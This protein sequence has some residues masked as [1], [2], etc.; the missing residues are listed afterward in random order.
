MVEFEYREEESGIFGRVF[1]PVITAEVKGKDE[2]KTFIGYVDSGADISIAP[3]SFGKAL[4]LPLSKNLKEVKGI[5]DARVPIS[6]HKVD[7]KIGNVVLKV[8]FAIA[9]IE[10]IPYVLGRADVFKFFSINF[11]EKLKKVVFEKEV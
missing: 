2:W 10:K 4:G 9:L 5:G 1:R 3:K 8:N 7:M 6:I 11:R